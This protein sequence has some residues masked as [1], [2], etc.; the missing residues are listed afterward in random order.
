M[1]NRSISTRRM[2]ARHQLIHSWFFCQSALNP[3]SILGKLFPPLQSL[4]LYWC[5]YEQ[6]APNKLLSISHSP[7]V[8]YNSNAYLLNIFVVYRLSAFC[9]IISKK[10]LPG[11][12]F[13]YWKNLHLFEPITQKNNILNSWSNS[14]RT[15]FVGNFI[16]HMLPKMNNALNLRL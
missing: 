11:V 6:P 10:F 5:F 1:N 12:F 9:N 2:P 4:Q 3:H 8:M 7:N 13:W 14:W 15:I 16:L